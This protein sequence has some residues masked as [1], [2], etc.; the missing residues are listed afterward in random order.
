MG[1]IRISVD[2][3]DRTLSFDLFENPRQIGPGT[4]VAVPGNAELIMGRMQMRK[5][6][7][8]PETLELVLSFSSGVVSSLVASWLY[9]KLKGR[10]NTTLCIEEQKVEIEEGQIKRVFTR[11]VELRDE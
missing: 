11:F 10:R 6:F 8:F 5:A 1:T 3:D 2:T 4:R 7:G 9:G